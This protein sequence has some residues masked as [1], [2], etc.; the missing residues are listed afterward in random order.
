MIKVKLLPIKKLMEGPSELEK[1]INQNRIEDGHLLV[2][3]QQEKNIVTG[4]I[5][6]I[7]G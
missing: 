4:T 7:T 3:G 1:R 5:K 2:T 6:I